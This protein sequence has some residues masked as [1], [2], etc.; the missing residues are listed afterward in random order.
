[1]HP[2]IRSVVG[3]VLEETMDRAAVIYQATDGGYFMERLYATGEKSTGI[4][5]T[6][7]DLVTELARLFESDDPHSE[8]HITIE[9]KR[10]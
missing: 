6:F 3:F 7:E 2:G 1:M 9:R 8:M 4:H 10:A 5:G